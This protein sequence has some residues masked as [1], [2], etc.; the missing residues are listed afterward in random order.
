M[1][2]RFT[3]LKPVE[4][5]YIK[6][7]IHDC[8]THRTVVD[9]NGIYFDI[10]KAVDFVCDRGTPV[11][12]AREGIVKIVVDGR[13]KIWDKEQEPPDGFFESD[14]ERNGNYVVIEHESEYGERSVYCHL[15]P[16]TIKVKEGQQVNE[17]E[18]IGLSGHNGQSLGPHLHF[19]VGTWKTPKRFI[20]KRIRWK[21]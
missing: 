7:E 17:G 9:D 19:C 10:T 1:D 15:K 6:R 18:I 8:P 3:Y 5:R 2:T 21:F 4:D 12:A 20:S 11:K 13:T 14:D 16:G